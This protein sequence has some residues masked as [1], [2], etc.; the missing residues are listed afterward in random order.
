MLAALLSVFVC[1]QI[2]VLF[3][4]DRD[5]HRPEER[6]SDVYG[7][8]VRAGMA[9]D[10][11]DNLEVIDLQRL[12]Q[13]EAIIM[14]ANQSKHAEVPL[15]FMQSLTRYLREGGGFVALHCTSGCFPKSPSWFKLIGARFK[16][17]GAE[18]FQPQI[19]SNHSSLEGWANFNAWDETYIQ[20]HVD[21][22]REILAMRG[23]EPWTWIKEIGAGRLFYTAS[24]HDERVWREPAFADLLIRA[25]KYVSDREEI[26]RPD[27]GFSYKENVWVPNYEGHEEQGLFQNP[28]TPKQALE[29]LVVPAG[30]E[31][32]LFASEPMVKNPVALTW[33]ERGRCWVIESIGYPGDRSGR[34]CISILEDTDQDGVA[35]KKTIFA[36]GLTLPTSLLKVDGGLIVAQA[37]HLLFLSDNDNDDRV[38]EEHVLLDGFGVW[39]T[40]AGP[41]NL[42]WGPDN[43]IWGTVGYAGYQKDDLSFSSGLWR[44]RF[45]EAHPEFMAQFS[46]NTWGLGF[47]S[48]DEIWGS[49]ANNSPSFL[50]GIP[51]STL[52]QP[53]FESARIHP[54]TK[55]IQQGDF[56]G[57]FTAAAG[58]DFLSGVHFPHHWSRS[59]AICEPTARL[60]ARQ[61][62]FDFKSG[63]RIRD[64]FNLIA[65]LDEWFCPVQAQVGPDGALWVA[66][67]SQFLVLHNLPG[68]PDKGLPSVEYDSGNAH[69]NPLRD[70]E[71]GRIFRIFKKGISALPEFDLSDND[72]GLLLNALKSSNNFWRVVARR[73]LV[74]KNMIGVIGILHQTIRKELSGA[75]DALR[76]LAS[77]SDFK[78]D[79]MG[80]WRT[81]L[82]AIIQGENIGLKKSFLRLMPKDDAH[83]LI[84]AQTKWLSSDNS[85]LQRHALAAASKLP[86]SFAIASELISAWKIL[87]RSDF[88]LKEA[89]KLACNAHAGAL[90]AL[91]AD[92]S[93]ILE[94]IQ[95]TAIVNYEGDVS[96]GEKLF[97]N[98]PANCLSCHPGVGPSLKGLGRRLSKAEIKKS[99]LEPNY[100]RAPGWEDNPAIM[101]QVTSFL[102]AQDLADIVEYLATL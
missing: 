15:G 2:D 62:V 64:C 49:T 30:M 45:G 69:V 93:D 1:A 13:Y 8:L 39:D 41:A 96:R 4:G 92:S 72:A 78:D 88:W 46:N 55:R 12:R 84:L 76:A 58:H 35:D 28:S 37:P 22:N 102:S 6:L 42:R 99:I 61:E 9:I 33:D 67:F 14:Y 71:H 94:L 47:S 11:E 17:H 59:V 52:A 40:H 26:A 87:D 43:S 23:A 81:T 51:G 19:I 60:V 91:V 79:K 100:N 70:N 80:M 7:V 44:W 54:I 85:A 36:E 73:I 89:M 66:D 65:S 38:D 25:V 57:N 75:V 18:I 3:I 27:L 77:I 74:E 83:A 82:N 16:S 10:Y 20:E 24:G 31:A 53:S 32:Q 21:D 86:E 98:N 5:F 63:A 68:N 56:F 90:T 95:D 48:D 101:P 97:A 50:V 34:D 29:A